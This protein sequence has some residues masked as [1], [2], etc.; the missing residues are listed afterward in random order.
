MQ[1]PI[2]WILVLVVAVAAG[3]I[4]LY[5]GT[6]TAKTSSQ[7]ELDKARE[8]ADERVKTAEEKAQ[9]V[10]REV[11]AQRKEMLLQAKDQSHQ[12]R[13]EVEAEYRERRGEVQRQERRLQQ[14][15]ENLDRKLETHRKARA[16]APAKGARTRSGG[17]TA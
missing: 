5:I 11:E 9:V 14:K 13:N 7:A 6:R 4:G 2:M 10:L 17:S 16:D 3:A 15:E 8:L 12:I 1:D